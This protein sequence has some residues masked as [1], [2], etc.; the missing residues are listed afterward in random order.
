MAA[1]E[2]DTVRSENTGWRRSSRSMSG[3]CVEVACTAT[4]AHIRDS[5]N[6]RQI[7]DIPRTP[8]AEFIRHIALGAR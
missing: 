4:G 5:K 2:G 3:N 1:P 6:P 8:V 7:L